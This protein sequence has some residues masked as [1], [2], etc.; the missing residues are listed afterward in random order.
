[1]AGF[2][3]LRM[4]RVCGLLVAGLFVVAAG[5]FAAHAT[6]AAPTGTA[7][8][9]SVPEGSRLGSL[10]EHGGAAARSI[11]P[12]RPGGQQRVPIVDLYFGA[13][14]V[15]SIFLFVGRPTLGTGRHARF[16]PGSASRR[17]PP[18]ISVAH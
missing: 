10:V 2:E 18:T 3:H 9:V 15:A 7:G 6:A 8:V 13:A 17:G 4:R 1:M 12:L 16:E 11:S 14:L 5:S